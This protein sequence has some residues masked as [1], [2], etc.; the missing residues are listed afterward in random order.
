MKHNV[1]TFLVK[2]CL[3]SNIVSRC[4]KC[5]YFKLVYIKSGVV[6]QLEL[7]SLQFLRFWCSGIQS[8]LAFDC[9]LSFS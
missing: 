5:N 4:T 7:Y 1:F 9:D 6:S 8:L 2:S 3:E